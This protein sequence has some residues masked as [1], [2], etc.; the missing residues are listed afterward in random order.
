MTVRCGVLILS[1]IGVSVS[2][3]YLKGGLYCT[4]TR[5]AMVCLLHANVLVSQQDFGIHSMDVVIPHGPL[6]LHLSVITGVI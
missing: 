1:R 4:V 2:G 6:A 3:Q 5:L